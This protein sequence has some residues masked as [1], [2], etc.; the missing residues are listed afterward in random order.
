VSAA[1]VER[2]EAADVEADD[3]PPIAHCYCEVC[4]EGE[5]IAT[6]M[7]GTGHKPSRDLRHRRWLRD[8]Q[9]CV[10]CAAMEYQ[11]CPRCKS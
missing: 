7:C 6:S 8:E 1:T 5:E 10:V 11:P 3:Q 2:T 4:N 9:P